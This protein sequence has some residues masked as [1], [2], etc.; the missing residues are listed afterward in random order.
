VKVSENGDWVKPE[1]PGFFNVEDLKKG[2]TT[3]F[4][5]VDAGNSFFS[6]AT[7]KVAPYLNERLGFQIFS[8]ILMVIL[9][10]IFV[11]YRIQKRDDSNAK[12]KEVKR[13]SAFESIEDPI[14]KMMIEN[15][16]D[17]DFTINNIAHERSVSRSTLYRLWN[18]KHNES[19]LEYLTNLRLEYAENLIK[20]GELTITE[21]AYE[22]GFSSQSYFTKVFKKKHGITPSEYAKKFKNLDESV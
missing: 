12:E 16:R 5:S 19:I 15:F 7:I 14:I 10:F 11:N 20:S 2:E 4:F 9:G 8:V 3:V 22:S 17:S 21:I 13:E 1:N 18:D 6:A